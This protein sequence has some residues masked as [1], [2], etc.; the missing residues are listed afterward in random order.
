MMSSMRIVRDI[1]KAVGA[2]LFRIF[3]RTRFAKP[4]W[5]LL[6]R[7]SRR[8]FRNHP[9]ALTHVAER[10]VRELTRDGIARTSLLELFPAQ[11]ELLARLQAEAARLRAQG[12]TKG[13]KLF[14][15]QLLPD[16]PPLDLASPLLQTLVSPSVLGIANSYAHACSLFYFYT[17][18]VTTPVGEA[19]PVASQR[20]HRDPEDRMMLKVFVY[21]NEVDESAGPFMYVRGSQYSGTLGDLFPQQPPRGVY[22]SP[23]AVEARVP[24]SAITVA[25]GAAGSVIFAD[26]AGLH[27]GGLARNRERIMLTGGFY[28]EASPWPVLVSHPQGFLAELRAFAKK[29][30]A[31][32]FALTPRSRGIAG[33][34]FDRL[35]TVYK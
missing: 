14:L 15:E 8:L 7:R 26:T 21:L 11:P 20:W 2:S 31:V 25:T 19:A 35:H 17:L 22:P 29:D 1:T 27:R 18:N 9:Q 4:V 23:G 3:F 5:F 33:K 34:I 16:T 32:A 12:A 28:S 24:A 6:N 13:K 30:A 10:V